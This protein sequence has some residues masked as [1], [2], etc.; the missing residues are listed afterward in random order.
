MFATILAAPMRKEDGQI[1]VEKLMDRGVQTMCRVLQ[2]VWMTM[3]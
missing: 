3:W 2:W 1:M